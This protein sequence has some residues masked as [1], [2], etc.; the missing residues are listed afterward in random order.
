MRASSRLVD[1]VREDIDIG[2]RFD[3]GE[4]V[5]L[6]SI[7]LFSFDLILV[8]SPDL[9]HEGK[10]LHEL[11]DIRHHTLLQSDDT[12]FDPS[13]PDWAM[14]LATAGVEGVDP[15]RGI[16]F[17]QGELVIEA[18]IA[19]QG[20]ALVASVMAADAIESGHLVQSFETRLPVRL[21]FHL[22]TTVQKSSDP[23]VCAF[24]QWIINESEYLRKADVLSR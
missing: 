24:R 10:G 23:K 1:F 11:D 8:C 19:G 16:Y 17:S 3:T 15:T 22:I 5:G 20:V 13:W 9:I 7:Y 12:E 6:D 21:S 18:A 14:W 4:F 2:I